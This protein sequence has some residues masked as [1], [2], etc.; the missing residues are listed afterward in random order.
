MEGIDFGL[1]PLD[2]SLKSYID[3]CIEERKS[4]EEFMQQVL[5]CSGYFTAENFELSQDAEKRIKD[6]K[7]LKYGEK[8]DRTQPHWA[9]LNR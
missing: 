6:L 8:L 5:L 7:S 2:L 4:Q 9:F 3:K 1:M